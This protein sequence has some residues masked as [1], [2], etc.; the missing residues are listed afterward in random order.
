MLPGGR[1]RRRGVAPTAGPSMAPRRPRPARP[2]KGVGQGPPSLSLRGDRGDRLLERPSPGG[3]VHEHVEAGRGRAEEHGRWRC[4]TRPPIRSR[5]TASR[6]IAR[7]RPRRGWRPAPSGRG[8]R[9]GTGA[10]ARGRSRRSARPRRP[11][12]RRP[13]R[14]RPGRRPC[15]GRRRSARSG[16]IERAGRAITASGWVPCE[17]LTKRTPSSSPTGSRR[18]STP[19]KPALARRIASAGDAEAAGRPQTAASAFETLWRPGRASSATR[20][21]RPPA[22]AASPP[23]VR[24][25]VRRGGHDPVVDDADAAGTVA[26][27][28]YRTAGARA[29]PA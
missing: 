27:S 1:P 2:P 3:V 6:A 9:R 28:R 12:R 7:R 25:G 10:R 23:P 16:R 5:A 24:A 13:G 21:D 8:R 20:Q 11:A 14:A 29:R 19:V 26:P 4:R 22:V 18:C 17:S 15:P